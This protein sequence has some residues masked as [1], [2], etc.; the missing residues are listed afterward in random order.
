MEN[1]HSFLATGESC[2]VTPGTFLATGESCG[3][4]TYKKDSSIYSS[5]VGIKDFDT[6]GSVMVKRGKDTPIPQ[7]GSVV[8]GRVTKISVS[9]ANIEILVVDTHPLKRSFKGI[10]RKQDVRVI[11]VDRVRMQ[12]C[13]HPGDIVRAQVVS[14]GDAQAYQLTTAQNEY[15]V[16]FAKSLA[17]HSMVPVS[18]K[19]MQCP[20]TKCIELRK[21][22][23]AYIISLCDKE[24]GAKPSL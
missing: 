2:I 22:K 17:G 5:L 13:F 14:L 24:T 16:I 1:S 7:I 20:V 3:A 12:E 10:I 19:E 6:S 4:G 11:D 21:C 8:I 15:G 18:W 9:Q 23:H